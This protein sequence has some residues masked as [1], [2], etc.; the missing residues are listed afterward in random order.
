MCE[1]PTPRKKKSA[2]S[3]LAFILLLLFLFCFQKV[4]KS[5]V[6]VS[7]SWSERRYPVALYT[8]VH[9]IV[10]GQ[11]LSTFCRDKPMIFT[12]FEEVTLQVKKK[13]C[14]LQQISASGCVFYNLGLSCCLSHHWW[15]FWGKLPT[16]ALAT[17]LFSLFNMFA[18]F[19]PQ[20]STRWPA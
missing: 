15:T 17:V 19:F 11:N 5:S 7:L 1:P 4:V 16:F 12:G 3:F 18:S 20:C 2:R 9:H 13:F 14:H 6:M 8:S 10:C